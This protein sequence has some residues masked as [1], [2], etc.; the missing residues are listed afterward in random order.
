MDS[1]ITIYEVCGRQGFNGYSAVF[2]KATDKKT[3]VIKAL[4]EFEKYHKGITES[5]ENGAID[6]HVENVFADSDVYYNEA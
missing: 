3:A 5:Y 4:T 1:E 2:V 6:F